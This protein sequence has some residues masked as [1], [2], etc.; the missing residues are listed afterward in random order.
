MVSASCLT[1]QTVSIWDDVNDHVVNKNVE[2]WRNAKVIVFLVNHKILFHT[3]FAEIV[4]KSFENRSKSILLEESPST[5][6]AW[7]Q[8][9][10]TKCW[11]SQK[12]INGARKKREILVALGDTV[13]ALE[14]PKFD[15]ERKVRYIK[16]IIANAE[17]IEDLKKEASAMDLSIVTDWLNDLE[18]YQKEIED[19]QE[20]LRQWILIIHKRY[21]SQ[22]IRRTYHE[23]QTNL[24]NCIEKSL[25]KDRVFVICGINHGNVTISRHQEEAKRLTK[26]LSE[27][28]KFVLIQF[29]CNY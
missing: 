29:G 10:P 5:L 3:L 4:I 8:I 14:D 9:L 19:L 7:S 15:T 24:I 21:G 22:L 17:R 28:T 16:Q 27:N 13:N 12:M 18:T 11:E 23:R 2:Y 6:E 26:F 25:D 1:P 20:K